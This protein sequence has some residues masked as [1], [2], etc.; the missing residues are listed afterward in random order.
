MADNDLGTSSSENPLDVKDMRQTE[1]A[2]DPDSTEDIAEGLLCSNSSNSPDKQ[3]VCGHRTVPSKLS[4]LMDG[5]LDTN[6]PNEEVLNS[7]HQ[8]PEVQKYISFSLPLMEAASSPGDR[9]TSNKPVSRPASSIDFDSD[10]ELCSEITLTYTEEFSDDDLEYLECSD[11]MTGHSNAI[12][13]RDLQGTERVFLLESDDEELEFSECCLGGCEHFL[14]E[15]GCEPLVSDDTGPMDATA[16]LCGYHSASQE[17][18][19]RGSLTST[20]GAASPQ[21]GMTLPV[22]PHQDGT[23]VVTDP[24]RHKPPT[25][26]GAAEV[27]YPGIQGE[28]RDGHQAGKEFASDNLL[29]MD[30]AVTEREGKH[31]PGELGKSG[32]SQC[33]ET[34]AEKRVGGKDLLS[35][36]GSEKPARVRRPG[37]KG[38][39]KKLNP[40]LE[41]RATEASLNRL[42]P[43]GPVKHPLTPSDKR[44]SSHAKAEATDLNSQFRAGGCA[45]PTQAEQGAK[46]LQTPPGSL[47]KEGN[48]DLQGEGVWVKNVLETSSV[49]DWG[50]HPQVRL[51]F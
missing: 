32:M 26:P 1:E 14:S 42:Y 50:D 33:L 48:L 24:G 45:I 7:S 18:E 5:A 11:V 15:M 36:R 49:P 6:G 41:E 35:R 47:S 20:H 40:K 19:V 37:I 16:G 4:R 21:T 13:Q 43:R 22:G 3:D 12:W 17:V 34:L 8:N 23:S 38:K 2:C 25:A 27:G 9:A 30:K 46:I 29:N 44:E 10:Y 28:T 51:L 31:L 39:A